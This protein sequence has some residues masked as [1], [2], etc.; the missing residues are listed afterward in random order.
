[1]SG[2]S[3]FRLRSL[4]TAATGAAIALL[5]VT[6][7]TARAPI[8]HPSVST[9][10]RGNAMPDAPAGRGGST[11]T[12]QETYDKLPLS[13]EPNVGQVDSGVEFVARG[14]G[15]TLFLTRGDAVLT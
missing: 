10:S 2:P 8:D 13:F 4:R 6:G 9:P 1:M 14:R 12:V 5:A 3:H 7:G 15:Y 11:A